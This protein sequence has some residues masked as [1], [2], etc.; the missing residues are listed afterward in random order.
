MYDSGSK[1]LIGC[2]CDA[3]MKKCQD[4][5]CG[6]I[7]HFKGNWCCARCKV[8]QGHGVKCTKCWY[9]PCDEDDGPPLRGICQMLHE[10][11]PE[12]SQEEVG[13]QQC[14]E[15]GL[16]LPCLHTR[17]TLK[18]VNEEKGE[19]R[20]KAFKCP[21]SSPEAWLEERSTPPWVNPTSIHS[22]PPDLEER[23]TP[24]W[25][26]SQVGGNLK[27]VKRRIRPSEEKNLYEHL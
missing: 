22:T 20:T 26:Y 14:L 4:P 12:G 24:L 19:P 10:E 27:T 3:I 5:S 8:G 21:E 11:P 17:E 7:A 23:S 9:L 1:L 6:R 13:Y 15:E 2:R 18:R 16:K 25:V